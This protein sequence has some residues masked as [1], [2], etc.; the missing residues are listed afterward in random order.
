MRRLMALAALLALPAVA[1]N[2]LANPGF[3]DLTG[4]APTR[5]DKFLQ[6]KP[7]AEATLTDMPHGGK[8]AVKLHV[9]SPYEKEPVNNWSQNLMGEFGGATLRISGFIRVEEAKEAAIWLQMWRERPLSVLEAASTSVDTP[10]YG[11]VDW[12]QVSME[13]NVPEGTDFVTLRCVLLGTGTAWFDD[14]V[15]ERVDAAQPEEA[16][17]SPD[18]SDPLDAVGELESM[19]NPEETVLPFFD[20]LETEVLR[21]R[22]ANAVLTDT[23]EEIQGVNQ[24]LLEEMTAIREELRRIKEER[25]RDAPDLEGGDRAAPEADTTLRELP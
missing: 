15:V 1:D 14:L 6:P 5:W 23:L 24:S 18:E 13:V 25:G 10:V 3:E 17:P 19:E 8:Y 2:L 16:E 11:S 7:G 9:P 21:L 20:E 4:D 22:E 12:Q